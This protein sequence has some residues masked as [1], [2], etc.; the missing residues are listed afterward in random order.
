MPR[1]PSD[2]SFE[3]W[4]TYVFDHPILEPQ[5]WFEVLP[6]EED[7]SWDEDAVPTRTLAYMTRLFSSPAFLIDRFTHAKVDQGLNFL[8]S[9]ACSNHM[10]VLTNA[11]LPVEDRCACIEAM[12]ILYRDLMAPLYGN[13]LGHLR[14]GEEDPAHPNF[15][16]YMWWD[17]IPLSPM[18]GG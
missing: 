16:C 6:E 14:T 7:C 12:H 10:F 4:V 15:S 1:L 13:D 11:N 9:N 18:E 5:W 2:I 8:V 17:I 3:R